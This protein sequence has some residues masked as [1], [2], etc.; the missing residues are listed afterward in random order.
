MGILAV[1]I[2]GGLGS[3][4]RYLVGKL[5]NAA[6]AASFPLGTFVVN[7]VGCFLIGFLFAAFEERAVPTE[8]RL[9]TIT[10]FLGGFTTFSSFGLETVNLLKGGETG[11]ALANV[12]LSV[13]LGLAF[14]V[15]GMAAAGLV[16]KRR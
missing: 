9:L 8:L 5:A 6:G 16:L 1:F 3:A 15:L 7:A 4:S 13:A 11:L 2:G 14:V 10:G 12:A